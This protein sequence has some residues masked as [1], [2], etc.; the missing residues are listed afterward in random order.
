MPSN[1]SIQSGRQSSPLCEVPAA[2][3]RAKGRRDVYVYFDNDVKVKAPFDALNLMRKLRLE[4]SVGEKPM[5][6]ASP[7]G[8]ARGT[9]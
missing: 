4:W 1:P 3:A 9:S 2:R 8:I 7:A 6:R 5:A